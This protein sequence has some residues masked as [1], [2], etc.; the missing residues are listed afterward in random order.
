[1]IQTESLLLLAQRMAAQMAA[2][3]SEPFRGQA[4]KDEPSQFRT[5]MEARARQ[6]QA[7]QDPARTQRAP[8]PEN[9]EQPQDEAIDAQTLAAA[10][11]AQPVILAVTPAPAD[12]PETVQAAQAALSLVHPQTDAAEQPAPQPEAPI[13]TEQAPL[14]AQPT[15]E[16]ADPQARQTNPETAQARA[17][18]PEEG[19]SRET[20][21][22]ITQFVQSRSGREEVEVLAHRPAEGTPL[23]RDLREI[24][25]KVGDGPA[26]E[27]ETPG[28][29][30]RLAERLAAE[31]DAGSETLVLKLTPE[32]L[33]TVTVE[34]TR[35]A[36]GG[37]T[38]ALHASTQRAANLLA[39]HASSLGGL[40]RA[41]QQGPVRIEVHTPEQADQQQ[42]QQ[43]EDGQGGHHPQ[44][45]ER[46]N[47]HAHTQDFLQQLRLGI[48]PDL[49]AG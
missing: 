2:R 34:L 42:Q 23:F 4:Q 7:G 46:R 13:R 16:A 3:P 19:I 28:L 37:L 30:S 25:V 49:E 39:D 43:R 38:V 14:P 33:G 1:M 40:L 10:L 11:T 48:L 20:G 18:A 9:P 6:S 41:N 5:L 21:E 47:H 12:T 17:A 32:Q 35:T 15:Q 44:Q 24:P 27:A 36:D 31:L 22:K 8:A 45:Q 29:E 26:L